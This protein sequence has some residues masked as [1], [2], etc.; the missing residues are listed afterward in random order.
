MVS[1]NFDNLGMQKKWRVYRVVYTCKTYC[2]AF[3]AF[4]SSEFQADK[5]GLLSARFMD[6]ET[7][8]QK[9]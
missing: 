2:Q 4:I 1:Q 8:A 3:Y 6:K 9:A 5:L 7:K